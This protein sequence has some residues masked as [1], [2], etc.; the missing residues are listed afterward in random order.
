MGESADVVRVVFERFNSGEDDGVIALC[1]PEVYFHDPPEIPDSREYNGHDGMR[2]WLKNVRE[3][4]E[5]LQFQRWEV[6]ESGRCVLVEMSAEGEGSSSGVA[7]GWR[8]WTVWRV[9][10]GLITYQHGYSAE[11]DARSD[12][13]QG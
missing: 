5:G 1:A 7:V 9:R 12:F 13:E 2:R 6:E 3:P 8:I 10:D 4:L 11:A